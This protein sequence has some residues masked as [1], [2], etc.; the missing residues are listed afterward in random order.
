VLERDLE[1]KILVDVEVKYHT[2]AGEQ[3]HP[4]YLARG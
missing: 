2:V 4:R 1:M 3:K